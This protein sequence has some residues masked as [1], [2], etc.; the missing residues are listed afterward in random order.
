MKTTEDK[1]MAMEFVEALKK[2]ASRW[3]VCWLLT[4]IALTCL[5]VYVVYL[6]ND[7]SIIET[8]E[9]TQDAEGNNYNNIK[10]NGEIIYGET[11]D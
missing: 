11:K 2:N 6:L 4:F 8:T 10:N 7:T 3:F 1:S 9:I 5:V